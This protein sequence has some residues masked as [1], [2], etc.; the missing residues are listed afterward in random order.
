MLFVKLLSSKGLRVPISLS[1]SHNHSLE[2]VF[3]ETPELFKA[4]TLHLRA[5]ALCAPD[6]SLLPD[7]L[8]QAPTHLDLQPPPCLYLPHTPETLWPPHP[9]LPVSPPAARRTH[10]APPGPVELAAF[11]AVTLG[12]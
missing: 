6:D 8:P 10:P 3:P 12:C 2:A 11:L 7:C 4:S 5:T 9:A 1:H